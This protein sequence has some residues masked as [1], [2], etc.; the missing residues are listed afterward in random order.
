[1]TRFHETNTVIARLDLLIWSGRKDE[2]SLDEKGRW[3]E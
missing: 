1:M 3:K 2:E